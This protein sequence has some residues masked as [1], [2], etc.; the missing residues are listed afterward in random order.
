[1]SFGDGIS[2]YL[3]AHVPGDIVMKRGTIANSYSPCSTTSKEASGN[4]RG[5]TACASISNP[6]ALS[7]MVARN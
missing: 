4:H 7:G 1:M 5:T 6:P 2:V 3:D